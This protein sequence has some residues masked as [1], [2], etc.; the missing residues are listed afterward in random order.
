V[1]LVDLPI[2]DPTDPET[3]IGTVTVEIIDRITF[4]W[5]DGTMITL[6]LDEDEDG[7]V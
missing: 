2:L 6:A 1:H 7:D 3:T 4:A 5:P